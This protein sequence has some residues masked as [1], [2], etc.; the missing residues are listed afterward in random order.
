MLATMQEAVQGIFPAS[1]EVQQKSLN[2]VPM[3]PQPRKA[4]LANSMTAQPWLI[5]FTDELMPLS[6]NG[7]AV[8]MQIPM[9]ARKIN[10]NWACR[11]Q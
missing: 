7:A 4:Y 11:L 10:E 8:E 3:Q 9:T 2:R 6:K 1:L 5:C